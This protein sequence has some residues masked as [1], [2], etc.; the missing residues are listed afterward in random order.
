[1][2]KAGALWLRNVGVWALLLLLGAA[3]LILSRAHVGSLETPVCLT[4][5]TLMA[6]L[7]LV[8]FMELFRERF[9]VALAPAVGVFLLLLLVTLV[10]TDVATRMTFPKRVLPYRDGDSP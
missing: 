6:L 9:S 8:F 1:M 10:A 2:T 3:S 4:L 7:V 5:A